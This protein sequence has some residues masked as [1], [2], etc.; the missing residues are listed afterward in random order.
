VQ[1][2]AYDWH[3]VVARHQVTIVRSDR[4][5]KDWA[6]GILARALEKLS[7]RIPTFRGIGS[8]GFDG[9]DS[10]EPSINEPSFEGGHSA[11]FQSGFDSIVNFLT[12]PEPTPLPEVNLASPRWFRFLHK[13]A[14]I[15]IPSAVGL[16]V[17]IMVRILL[18]VVFPIS[19]LPGNTGAFLAVL[20]VG[21]SVFALRRF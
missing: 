8:G 18:T 16:Y 11:M 5:S 17:A 19:F 20:I 14:D 4:C 21:L 10:G 12:A 2:S 13:Y 6:V 15:I 1:Q 9:F 7:R 3:A